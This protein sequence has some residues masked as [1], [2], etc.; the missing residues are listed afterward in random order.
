MI[1]N[2]TILLAIKFGNNSIG[3]YP[4]PSKN[5]DSVVYFCG[6]M[7]NLSENQRLLKQLSSKNVEEIFSKII[8]DLSKYVN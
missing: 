7:K 2:S 8:K 5:S 4:T 3:L 6:T 1:Q